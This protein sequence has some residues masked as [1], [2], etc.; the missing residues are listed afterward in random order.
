[1]E[2]INYC[3][4]CGLTI[5]KDRESNFC[6]DICNLMPSNFNNQEATIYR[7]GYNRGKQEK[8]KEYADFVESM[9]NSLFEAEKKAKQEEKERIK[10]I[11]TDMPD[12]FPELESDAY[13]EAYKDAK[14]YMLTNI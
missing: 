4:R 1:M 10:K 7:D 9:N 13:D 5:P 6:S 12:T 11:I 14:R 2:K 3:K 8:D